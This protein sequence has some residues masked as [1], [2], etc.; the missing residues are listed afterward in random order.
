MAFIFR[1]ILLLSFLGL[2]FV[3]TKNRINNPDMRVRFLDDLE[4]NKRRLGHLGMWLKVLAA[5]L[6]AKG[7]T[8]ARRFIPLVKTGVVISAKGLLRLAGGI[9][10]KVISGAKELREDMKAFEFPRHKED[11]LD[12]LDGKVDKETPMSEGQSEPIAQR[13]LGERMFSRKP[14]PAPREVA[15]STPSLVREKQVQ[16]FQVTQ[17]AQAQMVASEVEIDGTILQE[18]EKWL[19]YAISKNPKNTSFYK[20]LGRIYLQ[21]NNPEDA[22]NCLEYALKLGSQDPEVRALLSEMRRGM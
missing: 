20:K 4:A 14:T 10:S 16:G 2:A 8:L 5:G 11:F 7:S 21:M 1:A 18:K 3:V 12:R 17:L 13:S 19:L 22:R 6:A 9:K 15:Q